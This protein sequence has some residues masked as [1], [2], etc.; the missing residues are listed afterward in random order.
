[1]PPIHV[2]P[3]TAHMRER[4]EKYFKGKLIAVYVG[5]T[6]VSLTPEGFAE[7]FVG[8][9]HEVDFFDI[10]LRHFGDGPDRFTMIPINT[11]KAVSEVG[12]VKASIQQ[13]R[14]EE[15]KRAAA[16]Q[17]IQERKVKGSSELDP[18]PSKE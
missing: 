2:D 11:I 12:S 7:T 8:Y 3:Y 18:K 10:V 17:A 13:T 15:E 1:M 6:Q 5:A 9:L 14:E 4:F 16:I